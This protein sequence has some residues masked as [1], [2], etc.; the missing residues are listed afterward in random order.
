MLCGDDCRPSLLQKPALGES[1]ATAPAAPCRVVAPGR[2]DGAFTM[3]VVLDRERD[4]RGQTECVAVLS[5]C[6]ATSR[7][8]L[9]LKARK[10]V[11]GETRLCID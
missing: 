4:S 10:G 6:E 7:L 9:P 5:S 1:V 3:L 2:R 8:R 11:R